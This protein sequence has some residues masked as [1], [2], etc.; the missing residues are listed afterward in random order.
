M[1]DIWGSIATLGG[2]LLSDWMASRNASSAASDAASAQI[3][4]ANAGI[5]EQRRQF[6]SIQQLLSPWIGSGM[7]ALAGQVDLL[8][9]RGAD[10]QQ[11]AIDSIAAGPEFTTML[12]QGENGILA[13]ASA[14]GGM[15]GG[16]VQGALA[17]Y[18][19][20]LLNSL[21]NQRFNRLGALSTAGQNSAGM[22]ATAGMQTGT[23]VSNLLGSIGSAQAGDALA[24]GAARAQIWNGISNG[25]GVM[26]GRSF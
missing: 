18:R 10:N 12:K 8:G 5:A 23:N 13:N 16:N 7:S 11:K 19:P 24:Q 4:S 14:T 26:A 9:L 21:I 3:A 1:S 20:T 6:D 2:G 22:Q 15:R 17:E 25:L